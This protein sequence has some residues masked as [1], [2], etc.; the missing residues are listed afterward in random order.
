MEIIFYATAGS[1]DSATKVKVRQK[2]K[3]SRK[4]TF[5]NPKSAT[6]TDPFAST[7]IFAHLISLQLGFRKDNS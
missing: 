5:A 3:Q 7:N 6:L 1:T 2:L 4:V